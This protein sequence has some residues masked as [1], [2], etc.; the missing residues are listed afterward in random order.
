[1]FVLLINVKYSLK[2]SIFVFEYLFLIIADVLHVG[3]NDLPKI[4]QIMYEN[5]DQTLSS[6]TSSSATHSNVY[7]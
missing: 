7:F 1:M 5:Q 3:Q 6:L 4:F 2:T